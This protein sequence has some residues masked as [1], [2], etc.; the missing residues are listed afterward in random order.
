[1][2]IASKSTAEVEVLTPRKG[3]VVVTG[4]G[5]K[6]YVERGSLI[7]EDG[8]GFRRRKGQFYRANNG[9]DR[10][11]LIGH[12][13]SITLEALR[14]LNDVGAAIVQLDTDGTVVLTS[15]A[16]ALNDS[17]LRRA[18][19][20]AAT[21]HVGLEIVKDLLRAKIGAQ[22][23]VLSRFDDT[24]QVRLHIQEHIDSL[25][26][27]SDSHSLMVVE[28]QAALAYWSGWKAVQIQF[29][30]KDEP[31]VPDHWKR[32]E[33]RR[34]PL[35]G[36]PRLAGTPINSMLN[37]LY[38]ML[39]TEVRLATLTIGLDPGMGLLHNDQRSRDSFVF[40]VIEPLRPMIDEYLLDLL[41][42]RVF[43]RTD[44]HETRQG[45]IRIMPELAAVFA[46]FG[47]E[48]AKL[49]KPVVEQV[50]Q[51][52]A[53][54]D[55]KPFAIPTL[56][57]QSKRSEGREEI[58]QRPKSTSKPKPITTVQACLECGVILEDSNRRVCDD[59]LPEHTEKN[60][61]KFSPAGR[62]KLQELRAK[63]I[64]PSTSPE[65]N[66][67]RSESMTRRRKERELWEQQNPQAFVDPDW[68][69]HELVPALE[70]FTLGEI[71]EATGLSRQYCSFIRRGLK[72]PHPRHLESFRH[73]IKKSQKEFR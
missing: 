69:K 28:A 42:R 17:R 27:Y 30:R 48:M 53:E 25:S 8:V 39:E 56:L 71:A 46:E 5:V 57:T 45:V 4:F 64:D 16:T 41:Q 21:N 60:N 3:V 63:G 47:P 40:D 9:I 7:V 49:V 29:A 62:A 55:S 43:K 67:K 26:N 12:S 32:F 18:Q 73:L 10:L 68:F 70:S 15:I 66:A 36:N 34:S 44:F 19:A 65:A 13:G 23:Q 61:Q 51:R 33:T 20:I 24:D 37:Y 14:W 31:R 59:C 54:T 52:L 1:M 6:V 11:V 38:G 58:R 72:V 35:T 50:A 22:C 2:A